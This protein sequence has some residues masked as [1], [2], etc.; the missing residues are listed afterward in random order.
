MRVPYW[1]METDGAIVVDQFSEILPA[2]LP[3]RPLGSAER[4]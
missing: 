3:E 2:V 4:C 1:T